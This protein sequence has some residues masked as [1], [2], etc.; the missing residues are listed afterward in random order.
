[1][2]IILRYAIKISSDRTSLFTQPSRIYTEWIFIQSLCIPIYHVVS[3]FVQ[4][5]C[6]NSKTVLNLISCWSC[7]Y[8]NTGLFTYSQENHISHDVLFFKVYSDFFIC[9]MVVQI[10]CLMQ[11]VTSSDIQ[12][13][14]LLISPKEMPK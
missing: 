13:I 12:H 2:Q 10:K 11:F 9:K 1:M 3:L 14:L 8:F 7:K 5:Y 4:T 6:K